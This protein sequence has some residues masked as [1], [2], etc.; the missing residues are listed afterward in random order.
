LVDDE[1]VAIAGANSLLAK[2]NS[3]VAADLQQVP[4]VLRERG[5]GTLEVIEQALKGVGIEPD[6]LNIVLHLGSTEQLKIFCRFRRD[7]ACFGT[8]YR[9]RASTEN[10]ITTFGYKIFIFSVISGL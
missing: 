5:S 2:Q 3:F 7:C 6:Q 9:K 1:I 10:L 4:L 8:R